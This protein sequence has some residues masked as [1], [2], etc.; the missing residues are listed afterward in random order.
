[1]LDKAGTGFNLLV[2]ISFGRLDTSKF[3]T[4][5]RCSTIH[6]LYAFFVRTSSKDFHYWKNVELCVLNSCAL[7]FTM[8]CDWHDKEATDMTAK[9]LDAESI[10]PCVSHASICLCLHS[11]FRWWVKMQTARESLCNFLKHFASLTDARSDSTSW[12]SA[13]RLSSINDS[14]FQFYQIVLF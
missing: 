7:D 4:I 9:T 6:C 11:N 14:L 10:F 1:M 8:S 2:A 5:L 3:Q 12:Q 13:I